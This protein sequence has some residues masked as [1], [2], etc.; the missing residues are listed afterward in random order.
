[1]DK[2]KIGSAG[3]FYEYTKGKSPCIAFIHGL[4]ANCTAWQRE[5]AH[6]QKKGYSALRFDLRGHGMS[7][8]MTPKFN[9]FSRDLFALVRKNRLNKIILV[10]H[11]MG[12]MIALDYYK[13]H[14]KNVAAIILVDS[15]YRLSPETLKILAPIEFLVMQIIGYFANFRKKSR[16]MDFQRFRKKSD[17]RIIYELSSSLDAI[18]YSMDIVKDMGK[19]DF[20]RMLGRIKCPVLVIS[21]ENDEF[22]RISASRKMAG[23]IPEGH[24]KPIKGTHSSIIKRPREISGIIEE[25]IKHHL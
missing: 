23:M 4:G 19:T 16:H 8:K 24:F 22:F 7:S 5:F 11:S 20:F 18:P 13:K 15:S 1:M 25:F 14:S 21:S 17:F 10:G 2:L 12:G 9:D 6:F 3:I